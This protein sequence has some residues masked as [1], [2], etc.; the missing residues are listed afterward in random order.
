MGFDLNH[1]G[2]DR[3]P[4]DAHTFTGI[5]FWAKGAP[6]I[7]VMVLEPATVPASLQGQGGT[8]TPMG[9]FGCGDSHRANVALTASWEQ[10]AVPFMNL[11]QAGW[12]VTAAFDPAQI[13]SIQFAVD[14]VASFDFWIDDVGFY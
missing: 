3:K 7:H 5:V 8:C 12:G 4:Y 2:T 6:S 9:S 14:P 13:L 11:S 1:P 10:Y